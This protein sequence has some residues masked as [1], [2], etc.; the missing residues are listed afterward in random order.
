[1]I[2]SNLLENSS[3]SIIIYFIRFA[4][5]EEICE[6]RDTV[7]G[8]AFVLRYDS[9]IVEPQIKCALLEDTGEICSIM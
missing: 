9:T 5:H 8:I 1:M 2:C 3:K 7:F 4:I 6:A